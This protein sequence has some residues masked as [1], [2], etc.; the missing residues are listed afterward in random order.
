M[1]KRKLIKWTVS[2]IAIGCV[3]FYFLLPKQLFETPYSTILEDK[4]GILL[5][6]KIAADGQWRFP[7]EG[8]GDTLSSRYISALIAYE[9]R[10]F[11][12]HLGVN[13][14]SLARAARQNIRYRKAVSGASTIT[15][16]TISLYRGRKAKNVLEKIWE[17]VLAIRLECSA[18][19]EEI[20][21]MYA[22]HAPFGGNTVGYGAATWRYFG[23]HNKDLTWAEAALLAVLPNNPSSIHLAKNRSLLMGKRNRLLKTL[24]QRGLINNADLELYMEE[25]LPGKPYPMPSWAPHLL[26]SMPLLTDQLYLRSSIDY[27]IQRRLSDLIKTQGVALKGNQV[28]NAALCVAD[29]LTGEVVA[30]VGN[31]P[32]TGAEHGE[33]VDIIQSPR[34]TGS[35]LKPFLAMM[36]MQ[37]GMISTRTLLAD[38][39]INIDG[40]KP[41]NFTYDFEGAVPLED[42][43][44]KSLNIP[45]VLLL[46]QYN[47]ARCLQNLQR[48]GLQHLNQS[49]GHYG[50][51]LIVGGGESTLWELC[52]A[53]ASCARILSNFSLHS[54]KYDHSDVHPLRITRNTV[55]ERVEAFTTGGMDA[56]SIFTIFQV[57]SENTRPGKFDDWKISTG[58]DRI[59]WKTGTSIGFR[60]AWCIGVSGRYVVGVWIG[61]ADGEGRP[62][63]I[64]LETAAPLL[65]STF[66][67]LPRSHWFL[68]PFDGLKKI[69]ICKNSGLSPSENCPIDSV[70]VARDARQLPLCSF[71]KRIALDKEG[72]FQVNSSCYNPFQMTFKQYFVLPPTQQYYYSLKHPAYIQPPP[73]LSGCGNQTDSQQSPME[74]IYPNNVKKLFSPKDG[75][76][77]I[78][79]LTFIVA[80]RLPTIQLYW[81][82]DE[83]FIGTT[84][85]KN[86]LTIVVEKGQ[87]T[88][89]VVDEDGHTIRTSFEVKVSEK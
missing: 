19:K 23:K 44:R 45:F 13:L 59:A 3:I 11:Y 61:N 29:I 70:E 67:L 22:A 50:L 88:L 28:H 72:R 87:H 21:K 34:S 56:G 84:Q 25:P 62:G 4:N 30:Y 60:D 43:L 57:L 7:P 41:D 20:L 75:H 73:F 68:K 83:R 12:H 49:A 26:S 52:G 40:F 38:I 42:A 76:G 17:I 37:D 58:S 71:D 10:N 54:G 79:P 33:Q 31:I 47:I 36:A 86:E 5:G 51:S 15:M 46:K 55:S 14:R 53:Y 66:E 32:N 89:T 39:P 48:L 63:V 81:Y 77:S 69:A 2:G 85:D 82:L 80:H 8:G 18:S 9:D 64:G 35:L 65:F 1:S 16:Q 24:V 27:Q 78:N 6:A 74:F